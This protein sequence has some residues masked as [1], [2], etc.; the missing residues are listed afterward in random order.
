MYVNRRINRH[1]NVHA[2]IFTT[3]IIITENYL[4]NGTLQNAIIFYKR[5]RRLQQIR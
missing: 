1:I 2:L 5:T 4:K 3:Q